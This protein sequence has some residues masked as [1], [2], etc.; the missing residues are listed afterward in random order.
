MKIGL[1]EPEILAPKI[2]RLYKRRD[3]FCSPSS[4]KHL[5]NGRL[6]VSIPSDLNDVFNKYSERSGHSG[7]P[8][9]VK[10]GPLEPEIQAPKT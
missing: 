2:G 1:F 4:F 5:S 7:K 6:P 10:I 9:F 8:R 3:C